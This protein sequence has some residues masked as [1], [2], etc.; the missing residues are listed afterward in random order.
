MQA[1]IP[2]L[3]GSLCGD[4]FVPKGFGELDVVEDGQRRVDAL[5]ELL[6]RIVEE[7]KTVSTAKALRLFL[8]V[9][10]I[11]VVGMEHE[12]DV[13]G[14]KGKVGKI[15]AVE[16]AL[17]GVLLTLHLEYSVVVFGERLGGEDVGAPQLETISGSIEEDVPATFSEE[18]LAQFGFGLLGFLLSGPVTGL[19][20]DVW[21][22]L[23]T[24][25]IGRRR[26]VDAWLVDVTCIVVAGGVIKVFGAVVY[27]LT[28]TV[29][30]VEKLEM[31]F[32]MVEG[33]NLLCGAAET[34][35]DAIVDCLIELFAFL[36]GEAGSIADLDGG[37]VEGRSD[38]LDFGRR[39]LVRSA[40][41]GKVVVGQLSVGSE[42]KRAVVRAR[43]GA[44]AE[45]WSIAPC[46]CGRFYGK[47][48]CGGGE[49]VKSQRAVD[50]D[51]GPFK[52]RAVLGYS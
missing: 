51:R 50:T 47:T 36:F 40:T 39:T 52:R 31:A 17:C 29:E 11:E 13:D 23:C 46:H 43:G 20:I 33:A 26:S 3:L 37:F 45:R 19:W 12:G 18:L 38:L 16:F 48:R 34:D 14:R 24:W 27:G 10:R 8:F 6:Q 4:G 9:E 15:E 32:E 5:G 41:G 25:R 35:S 30:E 28:Q 22:G 7:G 44:V 42:L 2:R 1:E 49:E 21:H